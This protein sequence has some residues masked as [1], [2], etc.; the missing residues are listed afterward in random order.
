MR[1]E[2]YVNYAGSKTRRNGRCAN[3]AFENYVNYAGSKTEKGEVIEA[4]AFENYV[5]YAGSKTVNECL[6]VFVGLRT[7]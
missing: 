3:H 2:N 1:F 4:Q 6:V 5:N 7:M